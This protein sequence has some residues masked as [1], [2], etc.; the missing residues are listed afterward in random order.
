MVTEMCQ[1]PSR[2]DELRPYPSARWGTGPATR[3]PKVQPGGQYLLKIGSKAVH[4]LV[5]G[6]QGVGLTA[7]AVDIPDAQ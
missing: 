4:V 6:Q 7:V 1:E 3:P 5:I 2:R